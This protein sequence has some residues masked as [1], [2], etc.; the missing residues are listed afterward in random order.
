[1]NAEANALEVHRHTLMPQ[2]IL[3]PALIYILEV[4]SAELVATH[5]L[6]NVFEA[7]HK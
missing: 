7:S 4:Q 1:M 5:Y 3:L 6:S 2:R